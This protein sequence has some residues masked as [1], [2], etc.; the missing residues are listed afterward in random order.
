MEILMYEW[1]YDIEYVYNENCTKMINIKDLSLNHGFYMFIGSRSKFSGVLQCTVLPTA[2]KSERLGLKG[3]LI[4]WH[5]H[6][7]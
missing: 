6:Y 7:T 3:Q 2:P 5:H 4:S 1:A